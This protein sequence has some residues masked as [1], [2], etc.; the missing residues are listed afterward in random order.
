[1]APYLTFR[2]DILQKV[3]LFRTNKISHNEIGPYQ[4]SI[5][6]TAASINYPWMLTGHLNALSVL[7]CPKSQFHQFP[8]WTQFL[9]W[10]KWKWLLILKIG[11][12]S[13]FNIQIVKVWFY[14]YSYHLLKNAMLAYFAYATISWSWRD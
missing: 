2:Q 14:L 7:L 8:N 3:R 1:M 6:Y 5:N 11:S 13:F 12:N 10:F 4:K 9:Y